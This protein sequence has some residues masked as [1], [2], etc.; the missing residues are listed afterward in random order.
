MK[1]T[2]D[3]TLPLPS[4]FRRSQAVDSDGGAAPATVGRY[5]LLGE[6]GT[7]GMG[8]VV[9]AWDPELRRRVAALV[10]GSAS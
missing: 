10:H 8:R 9:E 6:L 2:L 1:E 4:E 7:G 3:D 5:T